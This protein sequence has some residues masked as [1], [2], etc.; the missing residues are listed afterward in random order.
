MLARVHPHPPSH[1]MSQHYQISKLAIDIET[2][3]N[4]AGELQMM[5]TKTNIGIYLQDL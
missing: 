1:T 2:L 5:S 3:A 4:Y